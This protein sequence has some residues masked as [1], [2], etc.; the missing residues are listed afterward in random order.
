MLAH[1]ARCLRLW[2]WVR[3]GLSSGRLCVRSARGAMAAV[4]VCACLRAPQALYPEMH[5]RM[6]LRALF[7]CTVR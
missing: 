2:D 5:V 7:S 6:S 4:A 3:K 1:P